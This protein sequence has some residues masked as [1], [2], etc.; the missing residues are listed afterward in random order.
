M[1]NPSET[2][3]LRSF[4]SMNITNASNSEVNAAFHLDEAV[5]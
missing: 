4:K 5:H 3:N 1:L 2:K